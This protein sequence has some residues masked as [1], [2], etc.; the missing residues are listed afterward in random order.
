MFESLREQ[1]L[2]IDIVIDIAPNDHGEMIRI[3][4]DLKDSLAINVEEASPADFIPL[5]K[6]YET[7]HKFIARFGSLDVF[8]FDLYS[9]TLSKIER[10]RVQDMED[11]LTLLQAGQIEWTQ[12]RNCFEDILPRFGQESLRQDPIEFQ[13]NFR[14]LETLWRE[15]SG[16][17]V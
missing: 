13:D 9:V 2:D 1:T 14:A 8:H 11:V 17:L 6:G 3:I 4:R 15:R 10:G 12:L 16:R 7:R 5:P